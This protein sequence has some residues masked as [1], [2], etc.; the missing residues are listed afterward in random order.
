MRSKAMNMNENVSYKEYAINA[1]IE[2][3]YSQDIVEKL[4]EAENDSEIAHILA[5]A[6]KDS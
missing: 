4:N 6:R 1:V 5:Q 3:G 2:L